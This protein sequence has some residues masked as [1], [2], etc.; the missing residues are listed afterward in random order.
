MLKTKT[1]AC[2]SLIIVVCCIIMLT[3]CIKGFKD[4]PK[5]TIIYNGNSI[6]AAQ[7]SYLWE[8]KG[9]E[10]NFTVDSYASIIN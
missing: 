2:I 6:D 9:K 5:L 10:K 3:S 8:P 1:T 4:I 7:G